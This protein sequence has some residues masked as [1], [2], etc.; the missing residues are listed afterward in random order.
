MA[1]PREKRT[2]KKTQEYNV[3]VHDI[4]ARLGDAPN[5][6]RR[7]AQIVDRVAENRMSMDDAIVELDQVE[8]DFDREMDSK[9]PPLPDLVPVK[10]T[11]SRGGGGGGGGERAETGGRDALASAGVD[12]HE[13]SQAL[14]TTMALAGGPAARNRFRGT[15]QEAEPVFCARAAVR[16]LMKRILGS[17]SQK[18]DTAVEDLLCAAIE[19]R[20]RQVLR[21][22]ASAARAAE[23]DPSEFG[24]VKVLYDPAVEL[25]R[26][27]GAEEVQQL[28]RDNLRKAEL[29][30]LAETDKDDV[31]V[32]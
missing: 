27:A 4:T 32:K 3:R 31:R 6:R 2:K 19:T 1:E 10:G 13:E 22:L 29:M 8:E 17:A 30:K 24:P 9:L 12:L 25:K 26:L 21:L 15:D 23:D 18:A 7:V 14:M 16:K 11:R 28:K 20:M 5:Q